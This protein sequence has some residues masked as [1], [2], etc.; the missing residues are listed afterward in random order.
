MF[1]VLF[2]DQI[3]GFEAFLELS[4][5]IEIE[6]LLEEGGLFGTQ[7]PLRRSGLCGRWHT[8]HV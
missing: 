8:E 7:E 5:F 3:G 2:Q 4:S 6:K 1:W